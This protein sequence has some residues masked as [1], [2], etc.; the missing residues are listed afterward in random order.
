[1]IAG[2][3]MIKQCRP[4]GGTIHFRRLPDWNAPMKK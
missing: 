4:Q 2:N 1:M 3:K